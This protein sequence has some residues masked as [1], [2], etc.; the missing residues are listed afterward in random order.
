MKWPDQQKGAVGDSP[1]RIDKL[2]A[3]VDKLM[4]KHT[5][6]DT[7]LGNMARKL[8]NHI[9]EPDGHHVAILAKKKKDRGKIK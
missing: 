3:L 4:D 6:L 1:D 8:E 5:E 9:W 7:K 2:K